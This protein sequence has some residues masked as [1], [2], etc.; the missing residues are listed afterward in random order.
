[1]HGCL[2]GR[3]VDFS[4]GHARHRQQGLFDPA[5]TG[6]AGHA[7]NVEHDVILRHAVTGGIH[8]MRQCAAGDA[9]GRGHGGRLGG[10]V[11]RDTLD[12]GDPGQGF[13]DPTDT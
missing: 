11:D 1:M 9:V 4:R 2:L 12:T 13:L 6:G 3:Q 8:R 7:V 10:Q 5:D